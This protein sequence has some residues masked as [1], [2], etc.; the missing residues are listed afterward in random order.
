[1]YIIYIYIY[2]YIYIYEYMEEYEQ[3][4]V[5][6]MEVCMYAKLVEWYEPNSL[7]VC[8]LYA[9]SCAQHVTWSTLALSLSALL[10]VPGLS[11]SLSAL[12]MY[13]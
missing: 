5:L 4:H 8:S 10:S 9:V 12:S 11:L 6:T 7:S 13:M 3:L 2:M 1:M